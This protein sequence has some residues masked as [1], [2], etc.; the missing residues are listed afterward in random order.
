MR[1]RCNLTI[2]SLL[3]ILL[4]V[5]GCTSTARVWMGDTSAAVVL[6]QV[7][8]SD[9]VLLVMRTG[10]DRACPIKGFDAEFVY[11]CK[12]PVAL[13]DIH[14]IRFRRLN[15]ERAMTLSDLRKGDQVTVDLRGGDVR[16]FLVSSVDA[17][18]LRGDGFEVMVS[19]ID[20]MRVTRNP[21]KPG[22]HNVLAG[23]GIVAAVA[24]MSFV[25]M[26]SQIGGTEGE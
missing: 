9:R 5:T 3:C 21:L 12:A 8:R 23:L 15:G 24:F 25:Y 10:Q 7:G 26:L 22:A 19:E 20:R 2:A 17:N 16:Q 6:P 1:Q 13:R 18:V 4:A 14:E 11:G